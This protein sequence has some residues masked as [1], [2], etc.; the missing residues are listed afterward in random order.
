MKHS[1][2]RDNKR[3]RLDS[4]I[5]DINELLVGEFT[6]QK[7][8]MISRISVSG[9]D[10]DSNRNSNSSG[11]ELGDSPEIPLRKVERKDS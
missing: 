5:I 7:E 8:D 3:F 6:K 4:E 1:K 11:S 10:K 9:S 2:F